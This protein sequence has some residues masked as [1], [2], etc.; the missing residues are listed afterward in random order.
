MPAKKIDL[1]GQRFGRL[2]VVEEAGHDK[3]KKALWRCVCDCGNETVVRGY[4]LRHKTEPTRSCGQGGECHSTY[5]RTGEAHPMYGRTGEANP[6]Y[7]RKGEAHPT[8]KGD[9]IGY[10]GAH[11]RVERLKGSASEH[12]CNDCGEWASD[13]SLDYAFASDPRGDDGN[14]RLLA[15]SPDPSRYQP[16]CSPCH[17]VWDNSLRVSR[18]AVAAGTFPLAVVA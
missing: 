7:G 8:W 13:W 15:Y 16:R 14:G 3:H 4:K 6:M 11:R 1:T 10:R 12:R 18:R 17:R 9:A 2:L 5:G